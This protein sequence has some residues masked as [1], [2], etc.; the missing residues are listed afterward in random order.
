MKA[1][2]ALER[3]DTNCP[4]APGS[5]RFSE[6]SVGTCCDAVGPGFGSKS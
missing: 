2:Q 1:F 3:F 5:F 4:L 6:T